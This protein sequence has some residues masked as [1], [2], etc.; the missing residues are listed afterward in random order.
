MRDPKVLDQVTAFVIK[1][2]RSQA[3][4]WKEN[5]RANPPVYHLDLAVSA[6]SKTSSFV[7]TSSQVERVSIRSLLITVYV[8]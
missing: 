6:G 7:I 8:C 3:P 4:N 1:Y 5:L 2:G